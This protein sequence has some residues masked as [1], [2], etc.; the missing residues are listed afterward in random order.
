MAT[1]TIKFV[2]NPNLVM[3]GRGTIDQATVAYYGT[4]TFSA[5]TDTYATGGLL[6][7][8]GSALLNLGPYSD[9]PPLDVSAYSQAGSGFNFQYN[10]ATSKLQIFAGG[11]SGTTSPSEVTNNTALNATTPSVF[12]DTIAFVAI[13]PRH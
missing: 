8:T 9:R 5:A 1:A 3:G 2:M 11:G 6:A 7:L 13:F 12:A 4:I 10:S